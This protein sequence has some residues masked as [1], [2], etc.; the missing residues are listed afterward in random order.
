MVALTQACHAH[1][2]NIRYDEVGVERE[3]GRFAR[4]FQGQ[5]RGAVA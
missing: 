1:F 2:R 4:Q 5:A 3:D